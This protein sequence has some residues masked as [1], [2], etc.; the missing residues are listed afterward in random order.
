[1]LDEAS[2]EETN[3]SLTNCLPT[4]ILLQISF[5]QEVTDLGLL[6]NLRVTSNAFEST[7]CFKGKLIGVESKLPEQI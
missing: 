3:S 5:L 6:C 1:M 2:S 7:W 4:L